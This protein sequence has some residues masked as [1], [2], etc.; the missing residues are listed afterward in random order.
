GI[1]D[2]NV[3]GV[4]TCALP[5]SLHHILVIRFLDTSLEA[6]LGSPFRPP[7]PFGDGPWPCLNPI[8]EQYRRPCIAVHLIREKSLKDHPVGLLDRKSTRLNSS[9]VSISYA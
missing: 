8:C 6:F 5:I 9:H 1:R 3:T 2:R 4:Q 7:R